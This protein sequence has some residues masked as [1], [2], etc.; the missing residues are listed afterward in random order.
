MDVYISLIKIG[1][2]KLQIYTFAKYLVLISSVIFVSVQFFLWRSIYATNELPIMGFESV[3]IYLVLAHLLTTIYPS[4]ASND[5]ASMVESGDIA[6]LLLKPIKISKSILFENVG[7]S[8]FN[9]IAIVLPTLIIVVL[10]FRVD[11]LV[12]AG[13]LFAFINIII[14]SYLFVYYFELFIGTIAFKTESIWG[15]QNLKFAIVA[16]LGGRF[17]PF[18]FYPE[19]ALKV[20]ELSPFRMIYDMPINYLMGTSNNVLTEIIVFQIIWIMIM[21]LVSSIFIG[22]SL[23]NLMVQGG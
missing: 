18:E 14:L 3:F 12:S 22:K 6:H 10:F 1:F 7:V 17:L 2:L 16:L 21:K 5:L 19:W 11:F 13:R 4:R 15:I 8:A 9:L 23:K 20:I